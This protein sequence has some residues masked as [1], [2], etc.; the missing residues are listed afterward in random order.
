MTRKFYGTIEISNGRIVCSDPCYYSGIWCADSFPA[1]NGLYR[2]Y[3]YHKDKKN[4]VLE[5]IHQD[6]DTK[7]VDWD[8]ADSACAVDSGT[9]GFFDKVYYDT[10]HDGELDEEWYNDNVVDADDYLI[11]DGAGAW[12]SSGYGDGMYHLQCVWCNKENDDADSVAGLR[13]LFIDDG[14]LWRD[15]ETE[16]NWMDYKEDGD[17]SYREFNELHE[18]TQSVEKVIQNITETAQRYNVKYD[19]GIEY[20]VYAKNALQDFRNEMSKCKY[21]MKKFCEENNMM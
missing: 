19:D 12:S 1:K 2:V 3:I 16:E 13:A 21:N 8:D 6:Y 20:L 17:T 7:S 9:F 15:V 11:T 10:Y 18:I 4:A 5:I 14:N